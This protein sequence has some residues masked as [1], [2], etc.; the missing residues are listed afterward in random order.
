MGC[1]G[2]PGIYSVDSYTRMFPPF[3]TDVSVRSPK[4]PH[5]FIATDT[6]FSADDDIVSRKS[7]QFDWGMLEA[8]WSMK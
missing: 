7:R 5:T 8:W 6:R 3:M 1:H 2:T 4:L